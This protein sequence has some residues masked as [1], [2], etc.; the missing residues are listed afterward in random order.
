MELSLSSLEVQNIQGQQF[1]VLVELGEADRAISIFSI[2]MSSPARKS[3]V[4]YPDVV[5]RKKVKDLRVDAWV[6]GSGSPN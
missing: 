3:L 6:I 2:A 5:V 4:A 1:S